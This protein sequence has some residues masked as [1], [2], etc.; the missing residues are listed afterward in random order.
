MSR[1]I[2][3]Q[4]RRLWLR[5]IVLL[6][7]II[8]AAFWTAA[9]IG[10][11]M[12]EN[13]GFGV[14]PWALLVIWILVSLPSLVLHSQIITDLVSYVLTGRT[15]FFPLMLEIANA[16]VPQDHLSDL[17]PAG[18]RAVR[19]F[20]GFATLAWFTSPVGSIAIWSLVVLTRLPKDAHLPA[21]SARGVIDLSRQLDFTVR[22]EMVHR[23]TPARA[24]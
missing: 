16:G 12:L 20:S 1:M 19:I 18:R 13:A 21:P 6:H 3:D 7:G 5:G 24:A 10:W 22:E 11:S 4:P 2:S 14:V 15:H 8:A 9:L 23:F 17:G